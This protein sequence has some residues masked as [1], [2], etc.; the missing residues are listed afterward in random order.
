[1]CVTAIWRLLMRDKL[2]MLSVW[3]AALAL[4]VATWYVLLRLM[5]WLLS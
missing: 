3:A 4:S 2:Y 5:V 1:M